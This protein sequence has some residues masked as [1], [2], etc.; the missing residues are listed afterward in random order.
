LK[1]GEKVMS[2]IVIGHPK[3]KYPYIPYREPF[4]VTNRR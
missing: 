2:A 4:K 3:V 1:K